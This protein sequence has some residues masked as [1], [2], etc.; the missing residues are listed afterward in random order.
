[1]VIIAKCG[2]RNRDWNGIEA[3][4]IEVEEGIEE[5]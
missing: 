5:L 1:M 3:I 2:G 4:L